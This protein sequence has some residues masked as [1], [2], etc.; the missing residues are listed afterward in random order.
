MKDLIRRYVSRHQILR[1]M[2]TPAVLARDAFLRRWIS[3][4]TLDRLIL[5]PPLFSVAE[6]LG[7]FYI[8]PRS[9][10]FSRLLMRGRYEPILAELVRYIINPGRDVV[11]VGANIGFY[12]VLGAKCTQKRVLAIEPTENALSL[13]RKNL[14]VNGVISRAV[15]YK[16][17]ASNREGSRFINVVAGREEYSSIG[18]LNHPAVQGEARS[19]Q[20]VAGNTID[21]IVSTYGLD[22]G[23]IKIDVEGMEHE[24]LAGATKVLESVRPKI[25][26]EF[27]PEILV[28]NGADPECLIDY[29]YELKYRIIDPH[30]PDLRPGTRPYG[31]ILAVPQEDYEEGELLAVVAAVHD[32]ATRY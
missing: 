3:R 18:G 15:I 31:D 32:R 29:F 22:P 23:L 5:E 11:D 10:L 13:L 19:Q 9:D 30:V 12:S 14:Q 27:S 20:R 4:K 21:N 16:G 6:F 24:V 1:K 2:L 28:R 7:S 8:D 17:V 25:L 26:C